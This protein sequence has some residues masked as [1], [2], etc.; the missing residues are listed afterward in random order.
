MNAPD[1]VLR[2]I[3]A[4][5]APPL[6]PPAPGWWVLAALLVLAT[7]AI[8]WWLR[9]RR[10]HRQAL[11]SLYDDTLE[12]ATS[13]AERVAA[14]ATL[15]R[16]AARRRDAAAER[17]E[18][19]AW[20]AWLDAHAGVP[21]FGARHADLLLE[22]GYRR[23]LPEADVRA[24]EFDARRAWRHLLFAN[25]GVMRRSRRAERRA[26]TDA[27]QPPRAKSQ[28]VDAPRVEQDGAAKSE[29]V[30]G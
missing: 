4:P 16:R 29:G 9:R 10:R 11:Q 26:K 12:A 15:L 28:G 21:G 19:D 17:L 24:L 6:W 20:L 8:G 18:G 7:L 5:V 30:R 14:V 3:H 23:D 2:D 1:L 25:R 13:P 22:G 27:A